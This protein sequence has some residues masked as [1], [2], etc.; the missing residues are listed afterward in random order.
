M[1]N[2]TEYKRQG[3]FKVENLWRQKI[4]RNVGNQKLLQK[5]VICERPITIVRAG[6]SRGSN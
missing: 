1:E 6:S 3:K 4:K 2:E 5:T